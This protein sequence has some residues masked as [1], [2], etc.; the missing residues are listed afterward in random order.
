M[1][2]A[3]ETPAAYVE[4]LAGVYSLATRAPIGRAECGCVNRSDGTPPEVHI[5]LR[6][7]HVDTFGDVHERCQGCGLGGLIVA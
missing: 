1:R 7:G 4:R 3:D 2:P 6:C 5:C